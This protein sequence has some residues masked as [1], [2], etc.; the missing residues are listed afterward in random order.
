MTLILEPGEPPAEDWHGAS[1]THLASTLVPDDCPR[2]IVAV[3][4]RQGAG[5]STLAAGLA[6]TWTDAGRAAGIVH[7][8]DLAWWQGL[9]RKSTRLNSSH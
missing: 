8:D 3:D 9:D 4:G 1:L 5:K 2:A 6:R 7:T